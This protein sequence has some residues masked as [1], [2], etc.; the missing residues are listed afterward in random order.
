MK[1]PRKPPSVP[2]V[3]LME[4]YGNVPNL[5]VKLKLERRDVGLCECELQGPHTLPEKVLLCTGRGHSTWRC[6]VQVSHGNHVA[7]ATAALCC[8]E[9]R[10]STVR[11]TKAGALHSILSL[12]ECH[13]HTWLLICSEHKWTQTG[14][15]G[16][17][18]GLVCHAVKA[19]G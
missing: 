15:Q 1:V 3:H 18:S 9:A 19:T 17:P 11:P 8:W 6:P 13:F 7:E 10:L 4:Q 16:R 14:T 5:S 2:F 12:R